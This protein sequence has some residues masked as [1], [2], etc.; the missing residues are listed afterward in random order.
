M[1]DNQQTDEVEE[2]Q[3]AENAPVGDAVAAPVYTG[4]KGKLDNFFILV[5]IH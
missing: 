1:V 3:P 5:F 2:K 4:F